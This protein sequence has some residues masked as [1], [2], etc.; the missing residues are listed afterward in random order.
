MDNDKCHQQI[1]F[2]I[3]VLGTEKKEGKKSRCFVEHLFFREMS[4]RP[5]H[6][7]PADLGYVD[8]SWT[9]CHGSKCAAEAASLTL[10]LVAEMLLTSPENRF[11][12]EKEWS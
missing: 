6:T 10:Y 12:V 8:E 3:S 1:L 11:L 2:H 9:T 7:V 4:P 5:W